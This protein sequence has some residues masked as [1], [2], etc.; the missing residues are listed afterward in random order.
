MMV[1][2]TSHHYVLNGCLESYCH[3]PLLWNGWEVLATLGSSAVATEEVVLI[4]NTL[5]NRT[6]AA[7]NFLPIYV[8]F[9]VRL[10]LFHHD[11]HSRSHCLVTAAEV[12]AHILISALC[13]EELGAV[14]KS[15]S[16][17]AEILPKNGD[18]KKY[19]ISKE[20]Q[21]QDVKIIACE[22]CFSNTTTGMERSNIL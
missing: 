19:E 20:W 1:L 18:E 14:L 22:Y 5:V 13:T 8:E 21:E 3:K 12:R 11:D 17:E 2:E 16:L 7:G 15:A 6:S 4:D 9:V 10:V